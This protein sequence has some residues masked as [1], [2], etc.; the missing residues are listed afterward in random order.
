MQALKMFGLYPIPLRR[1]ADYQTTSLDR[2]LKLTRLASAATTSF[3]IVANAV[4]AASVKS[5]TG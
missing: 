3:S 2:A 4:Y 1:Q 5:R